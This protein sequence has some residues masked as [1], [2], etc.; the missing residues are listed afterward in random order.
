MIQRLHYG[1]M[2]ACAV[3]LTSARGLH[4]MLT[5]AYG[6]RNFRKRARFKS[7]RHSVFDFWRARRILFLG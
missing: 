7:H 6:R 2:R 1:F 5:A 3:V 4:L